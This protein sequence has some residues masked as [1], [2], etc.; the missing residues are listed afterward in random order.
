MEFL[1]TPDQEAW[2][3][4]LEKT[5]AKQGNFQLRGPSGWCCL[6]RACKLAGITPRKVGVNEDTGLYT[7]IN[8]GDENAFL[9]DECRI[10]LPIS[11]VDKLHLR[12]DMGLI[13]GAN[14]Y[15]ELGGHTTLADLNDW[16][17]WTFKQI[18]RWIR[19]NPTAV[20]TRG[21]EED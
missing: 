6:G 1:F 7:L 9:F 4:D 15:P 8:K 2:L 3:N 12:G 11:V 18:A 5:R 16:H 10:R 14:N 17:G 19:K 21:L 13:K 20:F